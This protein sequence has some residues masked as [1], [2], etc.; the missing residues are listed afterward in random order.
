MEIL[1][2]GTALTLVICAALAGAGR[3]ERP[4]AICDGKIVSAID[5]TPRDPSFVA[6]PHQLRGVARAI[7][8]IHTTSTRQTISHFLLLQVGQPCTERHRAES[9]RILRL[10]PFLADA[11][12][13]AVPDSTGGVRIEV[14]TIDEIPTVVDMRVRGKRISQVRF[15]NANV[16]GQGLYLAGNVE[17]GLAYRT[18]FELHAVANQLFGQPQVLEL[19]AERSPVGSELTVGFG[20]AF[21]TDLQRSAW[22]VGISDI[23]RYVSFSPPDGDALSLEVRRQ[24]WDVG[25]VRR[26]GGR[27]RSAFVG[28]LMTHEDVRSAN[29]FVVVSDSGLLATNG[30]HLIDSVV[31]FRNARLNAV[32]GVRALSFMTVRGFDALR[33]VQDVAVGTQL[34]VLIGRTVGRF[35]SSD[36]DVFAAADFYGGVGSATSFAAVRLDGEARD[37][38]RANDWDSM[39]G[40]GRLAWYRKPAPAHVLISSLEFAGARNERVPFQLM[41]GDRQ[42]GVRGYSASRDAGALRGV[43]RVEERWSIGGLTSHDALGVASFVDVGRVWAG[44][45][46]FGVTS[47]AKVGIGAGLLAA[48]PPQSQRLWRLD[49]A[50]PASPDPNAHWELRL[51]GTWTR[52]FW[53][54]PDDVARGRSGAAPSAIFTWP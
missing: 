28:G 40:S 41:L 51:T 35:G 11:T 3:P 14:E 15:G 9:E 37:D 50:V 46:P 10:Q 16:G 8:V 43:A 6:V 21:V 1:N 17:Q 38:R 34:G 29:Q 42:G 18:G 5:I 48:F 39:I 19:V 36:D 54:E 2:G 27:Q 47:R 45:A 12:V 7:G 32:A 23:N 22:H 25:R 4:A 52:R 53:R 26:I 20:Q 24:L 31:P 13:L 33:A 30:L 44:D 49:V